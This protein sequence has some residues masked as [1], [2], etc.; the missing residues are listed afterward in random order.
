EDVYA[1]TSIVS[2]VGNA[3]VTATGARTQFGAIAR[4]LVEKA[5]PT[6]YERG[7]H[8]FGVIIMR[9]VIG[10]VL[11]VFLTQALL[12]RDPLESLLFAPGLGVGLTPEFLPMIITV[13]LGQGAQR[14]ARG[15]VIVKRLEA[16]ENLGTMDVLC[17]DKTGTLTR[18][19]VELEHHVDPWGNESE[20]PLRWA[21]VNSAL[22][23][24]LRSP[25]DA[26]ILAHEHPAIEAFR[27]VAE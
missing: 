8:S 26:A 11:L 15:K 21:C 14:M 25:L 22:E 23:A 6:E 18:G 17:T 20:L 7:V 9:T 27:K 13:T 5:P 3:I 4:A 24:G 16:I 1:G 10:L 12:R 2:G 19:A